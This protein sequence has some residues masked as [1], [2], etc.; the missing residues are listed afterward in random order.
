MKHVHGYFIAKLAP[1]EIV[2]D[3]EAVVVVVAGQTLGPLVQL[4]QVVRL[5]QLPIRLH[6]PFVESKVKSVHDGSP[7]HKT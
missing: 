2:P 1:Y 6:I 5:V 4:V 7:A 3:G